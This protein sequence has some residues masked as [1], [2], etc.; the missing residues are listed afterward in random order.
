MSAGVIRK[1]EGVSQQTG[2]AYGRMTLNGSIGVSND[3][4]TVGSPTT[5][6][7][8]TAD[9]SDDIT[10]NPATGEFTII[11]SGKYRPKAFHSAENRNDDIYGMLFIDGVEVERLL[12]QIPGT[13][14]T[15]AL[16]EFAKR[17]F[18]SGQVVTFRLAGSTADDVG[19]QNRDGIVEFFEIEQISSTESVLAGTVT[20][21]PLDRF[22]RSRSNYLTSNL[23]DTVDTPLDA[24]VLDVVNVAPST[25]NIV[26]NGDGTVTLK[27]GGS[28]KL[29][30]EVL[31]FADSTLD[32]NDTFYQWYNGSA[33]VG[34]KGASVS[35]SD[36]G[37]GFSS[38]VHF[39]GLL[40]AD[41]TFSV[42]NSEADNSGNAF[43]A[44][45][46]I[47][48]EMLPAS[49]V[50]MP[51]INTTDTPVN[52]QAASGYMDIGG[53]R[54]Q[55]GTETIT[56]DNQAIT[57]PAP[58][59]NTPSVTTNNATFS[60][61]F[62]MGRAVTTTGFISNAKNFNGAVITGIDLSWMAIGLKP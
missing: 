21:T 62:T 19:D 13:N 39:T 5:A 33:Y 34:S 31:Y 15:G 43:I 9:F 51:V 27:A 23:W 52:D 60:D 1:L 57:F 46:K 3:L 29:T 58:F 36:T 17:D 10:V 2:L 8:G 54:V 35:R 28:Y 6:V 32:T 42:R 59:G 12:W 26:D 20:P 55:W 37:G 16:F 53:M 7:Y 24:T 61:V 38:A 25:S 48:V 4:G 56:V 22:M 40:A 14:A 44:G 50:V 49:T 45:T 41:T 47:Y 18:T 30:A 11:K